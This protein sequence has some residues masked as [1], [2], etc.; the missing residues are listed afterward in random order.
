LDLRYTSI[1]EFA[2]SQINQYSTST[3]A[4]NAATGIYEILYAQKT[5]TKRDFSEPYTILS[6]PDY[7][8]ERWFFDI[9]RNFD[10]QIKKVLANDQLPVKS[11]YRPGLDFYAV[12]ANAGAFY[13]RNGGT[14]LAPDLAMQTTNLFWYGQWNN[15][16]TTTA[17]YERTVTWF[18]QHERPVNLFHVINGFWHSVIMMGY[19]PVSGYVLIKDS[20]GNTHLK[21]SWK[22]RGWFL[23]YT[24]GAIGV[25]SASSDNTSINPDQLVPTP[26]SR[27]Q[28]L[29]QFHNSDDLTIYQ[30]QLRTDKVVVVTFTSADC[31][32]CQEMKKYL[33]DLS[34]RASDF[35]VMEVD[36]SKLTAD[37][38]QKFI[39]TYGLSNRPKTSERREGEI[40]KSRA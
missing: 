10:S 6:G 3:C 28:K 15:G 14:P 35:L 4:Y 16:H 36:I 5:G 23:N 19:D 1:D 29:L 32:G 8:G 13:R 31:A 30:N 2:Q 12:Q 33:N 39:K 27:E 37:L 34:S 26:I 9:Y 11:F 21:G 40:P 18:L 22:S 7:P 25:Q 17:D 24:Y 38:A 20:L